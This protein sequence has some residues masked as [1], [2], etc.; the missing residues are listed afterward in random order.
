MCALENWLLIVTI[1]L[2]VGDGVYNMFDKCLF[3]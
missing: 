3:V 2:Y 1:V